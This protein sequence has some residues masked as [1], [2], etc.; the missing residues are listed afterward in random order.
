MKKPEIRKPWHRG[1]SPANLEG[2]KLK[3]DQ[4][5]G[6]DTDVNRI[7]ARFA[8]TG[9]LPQNDK[10]PFYGDVTSLQEDLTTTLEK[11]EIA[12]EEIAANQKRL[13]QE[14]ADVKKSEKAELEQLRAEK[15]ATLERQPEN[16]APSDP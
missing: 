3:V 9:Q 16:P 8:R 13:D 6:N 4:S 12:A 10:T 11:G 7:V 5:Q 15:A 14:L 2:Q 1:G